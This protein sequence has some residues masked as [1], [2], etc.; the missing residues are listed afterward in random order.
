MTATTPCA[1]VHP[2]PAP[3]SGPPSCCDHARTTCVQGG[4][5]EQGSVRPAA[6]VRCY[7]G[8]ISPAVAAHLDGSAMDRASVSC[9]AVVRFDFG[10]WCGLHLFTHGDFV[11]AERALEPS[12]VAGALGGPGRS[13]WG[14]WTLRADDPGFPNAGPTGRGG[15]PLLLIER[16]VVAGLGGFGGLAAGGDEDQHEARA[17]ETELSHSRSLADLRG[18]APSYPRRSRTRRPAR[19][20]DGETVTT[21][22]ACARGLAA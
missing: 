12:V 3:A 14:A 13:P 20:V 15:S 6:R 22:D 4:A 5:D 8:A 1:G 2:P 11:F 19:R 10:L 9:G 17:E 16:R 18:V 21:L 7:V